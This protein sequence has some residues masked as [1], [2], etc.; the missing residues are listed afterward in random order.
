MI[1]KSCSLSQL[2][3]KPRSCFL[4]RSKHD[5]VCFV[6]DRQRSLLV[7]RGLM[8]LTAVHCPMRYTFTILRPLCLSG[9]RLAFKNVSAIRGKEKTVI[10]ACATTAL[11]IV[12]DPCL[13]TDVR[14]A[15]VKSCRSRSSSTPDTCPMRPPQNGVHSCGGTYIMNGTLPSKRRR[16]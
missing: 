12:R 4:S 5:V 6:F 16:A 14:E 11:F 2:F 10:G 8:S 3:Q 1:I 9:S 13:W 15:V 7:L